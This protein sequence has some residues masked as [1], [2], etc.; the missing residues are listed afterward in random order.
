M[1]ETKRVALLARPGEARERLRVA[2]HEAGAEIVLEDDPNTLDTD[3]LGDSAP[4]VVLVALEPAI[5]DSLERFDSV[6][7]DPAVAVIFD[8]ADLAARRQ[9]WEAQRWARHLAAKLHGHRDVLPP[10]RE[11]DVGLQL[12]PGLPVTPAQL[13]EDAEISLHLEEAADMALELPS[14]D[15]AYTGGLQARQ[16]DAQVVDA[17]DWLRSASTS[18]ESASAPPPLPEPPAVVP[19]PLPAST[20]SST[21]DLSNLSLEPLEGGGV[22]ASA[23]T[24]GAV[25]VFA[26]IGGPDAVRK[27][28]ADLPTGFPKPV[29]VHLRLDGGRY[30]NLVRQMERVSHMP[31][32]LAEAGKAAEVGHVYVLPGDVVPFVEEGV[33]SFRSG[34]TIHAVIPQ[35]PPADSAVLLLSGSDTSLVEVTAALG[36]G[37]ALVM[38]QSQE[39]C[40]DPAAPKALAARGAELGSPAQI[41]QRLTDRWF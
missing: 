2:L 28:L 34:E 37:G 30:D 13:H 4:Q 36:N 26:G 6:L 11:E 8:E 31:V 23:R 25:L 41:A 32:L 35:L 14:D 3:A 17:D 27:L 22:A 38:G 40:Y 29:M 10:G 18:M 7:H 5:E 24:Q 39:G 12:E 19:P 21:F 33:V 16:L 9:G 20:S 15:F 1:S